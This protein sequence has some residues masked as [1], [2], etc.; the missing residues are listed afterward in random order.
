MFSKRR[1]LGK[2]QAEDLRFLSLQGKVLDKGRIW[3]GSDWVG[4]QVSSKP[5]RG[6]AGFMPAMLQNCTQLCMGSV[7]AQMGAVPQ[8]DVLW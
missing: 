6:R 4:E 5:P 7:S 1:S 8:P 3:L 2:L